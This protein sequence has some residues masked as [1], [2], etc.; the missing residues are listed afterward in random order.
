MDT[1]SKKTKVRK[2]SLDYLQYGFVAVPSKDGENP[3]CLQCGAT[4]TN[5][6]LKPSKL[7]NHLK[8]NH[9]DIHKMNGDQRKHY[10]EDKLDVYERQK[11]KAPV[12]FLKVQKKRPQCPVPLVLSS[13]STVFHTRSRKGF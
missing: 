11:V 3:Y 8:T 9:P 2:Y 10:F 1:S 12:S 13:P 7:E 6:A 5:H 4:L